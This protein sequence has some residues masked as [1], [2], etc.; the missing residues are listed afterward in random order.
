VSQT[1]FKPGISGIQIRC[2]T[3]SDILLGTNVSV[4]IKEAEKDRA[5]SI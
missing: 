1:R 2:V 5:C 3:A 4:R